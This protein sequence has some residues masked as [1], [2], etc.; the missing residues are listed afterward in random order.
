MLGD[1]T[2]LLNLKPIMQIR[3]LI[4]YY[5]AD[6]TWSIPLRRYIQLQ[7]SSSR[8]D[9]LLRILHIL[10]RSRNV[11]AAAKRYDPATWHCYS[12]ATQHQRSMLGG[13]ILLRSYLRNYLKSWEELIY[14]FMYE[15]ELETGR[16]RKFFNTNEWR[17]G[18][19]YT[20]H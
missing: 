14:D 17:I 3:E 8:S 1:I 2:N 12:A 16:Q 19:I 5:I 15:T 10:P 20:I 9:V 18:V 11:A 13:M 7:T 4:F 6:G